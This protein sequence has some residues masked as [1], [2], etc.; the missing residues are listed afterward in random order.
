MVRYH[1][2]VVGILLLLCALVPARSGWAGP[3]SDQLRAGIDRVFK[4]L[5]DPEL[6]GDKELNQRRTAIV[7][8]ASEIFDFG[9]MAK[10]SL[11]QYWP[12][13]TSAERGEF[14]RLFTEL[15]ERSYISKVDQ[16]GA[17]EMAVQGERI[18]GDYA[19]VRTTLPL[20]SGRDVS[21]DY[22]MR[23]T[24]DRWQVYDLSVDGI[25]LVASYRAQFNR[26]IRTSSYEAL[27]ARFKSQQAD[28]RARSAVSGG[29]PAR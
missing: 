8:A 11:G 1:A 10:R 17:H 16:Q 25:S 27:V 18:D 3:P 6:A 23:N 22:S 13:R 12:Q 2:R 7:A 15:V 9:E 24:D 21:I 28:L 19:V 20:S 14:V 5:G 26:I 4:I 29:Q